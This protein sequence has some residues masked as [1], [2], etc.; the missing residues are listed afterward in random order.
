[1]SKYISGQWVNVGDISPWHGQLWIKDEGPDQDYAECVEVISPADLESL[2]DNQL[3]V[4][5]GSVY[6]PDYDKDSRLSIIGKTPSLATWLDY[7]I[8]CIAYS[9]I[10]PNIYNGQIVVQHGRTVYEYSEKPDIVL[11]GNSDMQRHIID[12]YLN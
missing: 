5:I 6:M 11:H 3:L 9:G 2:A 8:A 12:K 10:D 1:M 7:A 4:T